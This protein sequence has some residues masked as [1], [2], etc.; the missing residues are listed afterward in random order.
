MFSCSTCQQAGI[1]S[2]ETLSADDSPGMYWF[3]FCSYF[4][5]SYIITACISIRGRF[6]AINSAIVSGRC[7][8][9]KYGMSPMAHVGNGCADLILVSKC[10]RFQYLRYLF[11]VA[12]H[13]KSP[14]SV[15]E[16]IFIFF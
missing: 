14:V 11:S 9:S 7:H 10:S 3:F 13:T 16:M 15:F 12:F 4:M 8:M 6:L 2:R 5:I 1:K